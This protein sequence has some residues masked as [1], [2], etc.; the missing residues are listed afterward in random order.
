MRRTNGSPD[1]DV[2]KLSV[3]GRKI[4]CGRRISTSDRQVMSLVFQIIISILALEPIKMTSI[5]QQNLNHR[6]SCRP[7]LAGNAYPDTSPF[8]VFRYPTIGGLDPDVLG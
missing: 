2:H 8:F 7:Y 5:P 3:Y 4:G 1:R 6:V